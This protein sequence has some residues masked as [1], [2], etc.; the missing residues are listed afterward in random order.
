MQVKWSFGLIVVVYFGLAGAVLNVQ[1]ADSKHF[2]AAG[3]V[4][5]AADI[6]LPD[7]SLP[8]LEGKAVSLRSFRG[9]VILLNFWTTW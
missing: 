4:R 5:F 2:L 7:I 9:K 6:D 8:N 1:A 3:L